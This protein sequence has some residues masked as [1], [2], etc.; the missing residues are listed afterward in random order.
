MTNNLLEI[1]KIVHG[2]RKGRESK[3]TIFQSR[4]SAEPRRCFLKVYFDP[5]SSEKYSVKENCMAYKIKKTQNFKDIESSFSYLS[6]Q[7]T[8]TWLSSLKKTGHLLMSFCFYNK[9]HHS[10]DNIS[11]KQCSASLIWWWSMSFGSSVKLSCVY[12]MEKWNYC[13]KWEP[14]RCF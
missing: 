6:E 10:L 4:A 12:C 3:E 9:K 1:L 8:C 11:L 7:N 14:L 2:E 5:V 13:G